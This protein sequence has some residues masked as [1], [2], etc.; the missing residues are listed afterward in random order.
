ML[1]LKTFRYTPLWSVLLN[2][3]LATGFYKSTK[4]PIVPCVSGGFVS[5]CWFLGVWGLWDGKQA[6]VLVKTLVVFFKRVVLV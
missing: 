3:S 4:L 6:M 5:V 2:I 1:I